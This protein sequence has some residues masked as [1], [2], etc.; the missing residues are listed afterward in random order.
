MDFDAD[1]LV[2]VATENG[3]TG[4]VRLET[5]DGVIYEGAFGLAD[6]AHG[7][8]NTP[9]TRFA[10]AS[11][12]KTFLALAVLSLV[13]D[14]TMSLDD[15]A[16]RWLGDDLPQ[17]DDAVT[18]RLL[19]THT[20]GVG[21]YLDDDSEKDEYL[22]PGGMQDYNCAE[23]FLP[24]LDQPMMF[25]P[26]TDFEYSNAGYVLLGVLAERASGVRFQQLIRD[27]VFAPAG[28]QGTDFL[29]SDA[30]PGDVAIGYL[31]PEGLRSNIF[32]LPIEGA[33]DG[34]AYIS[35]PDCHR[36]WRALDSG[37][38]V[39]DALVREMTTPPDGRDPDDDYGFGLWLPRPGAWQLNGEDS[40]V[41]FWSEYLPAARVSF[42]SVANLGDNAW[43]PGKFLRDWVRATYE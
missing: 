18:L 43:P 22:T 10:I 15:P 24:L 1:G 34:G 8:P 19:L 25:A 40:G 33:P 20:S 6:R 31:Y 2:A 39:P 37:A 4:A 32:H 17:V 38:I 26:G 21:E 11:G 12:S 27:R 3:F 30:L 13:A 42:T 5:D 14:G 36:F 7:V 29:R 28:L 35:L 16:R 41:S 23:D 9:Q